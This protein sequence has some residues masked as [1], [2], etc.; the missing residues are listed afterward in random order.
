[1]RFGLGVSPK[2]VE[3]IERFARWAYDT[4]WERLG[5]GGQVR[6]MYRGI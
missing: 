6:G 2:D 1:V 5:D 4:V 3:V